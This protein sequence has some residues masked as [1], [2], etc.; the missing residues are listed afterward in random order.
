[1]KS[2]WLVVLASLA[3]ILTSSSTGMTQASYIDS[4]TAVSNGFGAWTSVLWTQ[5]TQADF[6][7]G[8]L[9]NVDTSSAPGDVKLAVRS[10]WYSTGWS[11]RKK[12]TID[13]T[14]V[15]ADLTDFSVLLSLTSDADLASA[16][17]SNGNDIL[18]TSTNGVTKLDHEIERYVGGTG[19][20]VAW[21]RVPTLSSVTDT[22]IFIYYGNSS[23]GNQQNPTGVWNASYKS[24]WHL[25]ELTGTSIK[26]STTNSNDGTSQ[27]GVTLGTAGMIDGAESFDGIVGWTGLGTSSSLNFGANAPFTIEGWY[28][29]TESYGTIFS[30][31]HSTNDGADI[32]ICV[33]YDG[34]VDSAGRLM[35]LARQDSGSGGYARVTGPTVNNGNW[36]Y[37]VLTRN[38]GNT[39][40][41]FSDGVLQGT[42]SGSESG[43]AITTDIRA[44]ASERRWVQ[45]GYGN[46]DQRYLVGTIDEVRISNSQRSSP[47]ISTCYNNQ[48][49]PSTFHSLAAKEGPYVSSGTIASQV[50]DTGVAGANWDALFWNVTI[51]ANT[52]VT[53]EVRANDTLFIKDA[54]TPSWTS[55]GGT[56]P[57]TSGLLS[58]RYKQWRATLTTSDTSKTPSLNEVRVHFH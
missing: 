21:V 5:T 32:D 30:F 10:D 7:A 15:A 38:A 9:N 51:P 2:K 41:L 53:F 34:A 17:Q 26:D 46:A 44:L 57:V 56:S 52:N 33:G 8:V 39:I 22:A 28:K 47:W 35:G 3:L 12:I 20:L 37:F 24:V 42:N 36:H 45:V 49:S 6:N 55:V 48:V 11:Y 1:M 40:Q 16:A 29:T 14:K 4:E 18:F 43:G 50:L 23:C 25:N 31:R 13:H 19:Q 54:A 58:A 27:N